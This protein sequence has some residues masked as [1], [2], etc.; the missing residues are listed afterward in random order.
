M[1]KVIL[2]YKFPYWYHT[3]AE[4]EEDAFCIM[5]QLLKDEELSKGER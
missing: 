1:I 4:D 2:G 5:D 3:W